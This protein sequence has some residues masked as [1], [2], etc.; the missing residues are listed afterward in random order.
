MPRTN[1]QF[2]R[3]AR[4]PKRVKGLLALLVV[5][6]LATGAVVKFLQTTRGAIFLLDHGVESALPRVE[7]EVGTALKRSLEA[8]GL[9][10]Q[11]RVRSEGAPA[12]WDLPCDQDTDLLLVNVALTEAARGVG[13]VVRSSEETDNGRTLDFRVGT[14]SRITHRLTVRRLEPEVIAVEPPPPDKPKLAIVIDDLGYTDGGVV[15]EILELEMPLT[16]AILPELRHSSDVLAAAQRRRDH[17]VLLHLPMESDQRRRR[18]DLKSV[19]TQMSDAEI[20]SLLGEYL[21]SLP[22]VDGVNNHQG[23]RA[24]ESRRVMR[25]VCKVLKD[26]DLFF[27]DSLTSPE[28]VAYNV[29]IETGLRAAMN[30]EFIDDATDRREDVE[31]RLHQLAETA[32]RKGI[33]I[34][35]GHPHPWTLEALRDFDDYLKTIDVELVSLCDLI[36]SEK[37]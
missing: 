7:T 35:I 13:A 1:R 23:S 4:A 33:A 20:A 32:R 27:L 36:E 26:Y 34:G 18:G 15:R 8:T 10:Q 30:S 11:L 9:R 22:G 28:S 19:T 29:A 6:A 25:A 16:M 12:V 37:P 17:C 21:E 31:A 5:L 3:D 24:T 14:Q 2:E